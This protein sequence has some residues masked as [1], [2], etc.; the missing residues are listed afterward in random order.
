MKRKERLQAEIERTDRQAEQDRRRV[1]HLIL[2]RRE[3]AVMATDN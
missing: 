1:V 2:S 3:A